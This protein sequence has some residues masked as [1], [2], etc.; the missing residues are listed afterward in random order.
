MKK[1]LSK[2]DLRYLSTQNK[3]DLTYEKKLNTFFSKSLGNNAEKLRNFAKYVPRQS[4]SSFL[5][6]SEIF[7]NILKIHGNIIECGV[8]LCGGLLT[9]GNL[10]AIYEPYNHNRKIIGF[11]TF[12]GFQ[13]Y[14]KKDKKNKLSKKVGL[15]ISSE[16]D[17]KKSIELFD[18]NRPVGHIP[19]I[20]SIKGDAKK[21]IPSY[22]KNNKHLVIAMLCLDFDLYEPTKV[23]LKTF[24]P[25]MSRG[26]ILVFDELNQKPWP[27]ET[28]AV[29]EE[30]G[31]RK[32]KIRRFNY[33]PH[34]SYAILD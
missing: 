7:K 15:S 21:T 12:K 17:V 13:K 16:K 3:N 22:L 8:Y 26:S 24:L 4:V 18:L 20:I 14:N 25:R 29:L 11:D 23:A 5:A 30:C 27:G 34:L 9:C 6:K 10:S 33:T 31:I 28:L 1:K 32:L 2:F 19:K